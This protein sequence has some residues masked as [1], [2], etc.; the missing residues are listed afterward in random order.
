[1][2]KVQC[3]WNIYLRWK[4][5]AHR[6]NGRSSGIEPVYHTIQLS[7]REALDL[8]GTIRNDVQSVKVCRTNWI[9][10][11][12]VRNPADSFLSCFG[13]S[14]SA[15]FLFLYSLCKLKISYCPWVRMKGQ[16]IIRVFHGGANRL[17]DPAE[18]VLS[19]R[20]L[21]FGNCYSRV[22]AKNR[23]RLFLSAAPSAFPERKEKKMKYLKGD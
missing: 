16:R 19:F 20:A 8:A 23:T 14:L 11:G 5:R 9:R 10:L 1:M 15:G 2:Q 6:Y 12:S 17:R 7:C 4:R 18:P 3:L 22:S 21:F 13:I